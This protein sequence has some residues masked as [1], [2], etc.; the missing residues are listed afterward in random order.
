MSGQPNRKPNDPA[1]FRQDY[2]DALNLRAKVDDYNLQANKQY[3]ATGALPPAVTQMTDTRNTSE[4]LADTYKLKQSIIDD[5]KDVASSAMASLVVQRVEQDPLNGDGSFLQFIAQNAPEIV[6]QLK[7]KYKFGIKGDSNDVETMISYMRNMYAS[8]KDQTGTVKSF[9]DRPHGSTN[10]Q[11]AVQTATDYAKL[12][13]DLR[14]LSLKILRTNPQ[15][16]D[17]RELINSVVSVIQLSSGVANKDFIDGI[18][19]QLQIMIDQPQFYEPDFID[20]YNE[21]KTVISQLPK[22][23]QIRALITQLQKSSSNVNPELSKQI[24]VNI[25]SL[26]PNP[27]ILESWNDGGSN[28][29]LIVHYIIEQRRGITPL[30]RPPQPQPPPSQ[31]L[32]GLQGTVQGPPTEEGQYPRPTQQ[33]PQPHV[34]P[35]VPEAPQLQTH[36]GRQINVRGDL[37][38]FV[39]GISNNVRRGI[40]MNL[41]EDDIIHDVNRDTSNYWNQGLTDVQR[42][43]LRQKGITH[44]LLLLTPER[45][46]YH[47][48]DNIN[49]YFRS[50]PDADMMLDRATTEQIHTETLRDVY[51]DL[52]QNGATGEGLKKKRRGRPVGRGIGKSQ[53][54]IETKVDKASG[55][56]KNDIKKFVPF[57]KYFIHNVKLK[58][59]I[60]SLRQPSGVIVAG[61]SPTR[62]SDK[63]GHVIRT[64][65]GGGTPKFNELNGLSDEERDYLY[66]VSKKS[67]L[68]DK[69][70]VP[71]PS[72]DAME[73]DIHNF[74][75]MKGEIMAGNDSIDMI[76]KFKLLI[77]KLSKSGSLP[78]ND[79]HEILQE[80][81]VL[82]Y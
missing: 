79:V 51:E 72:K 52:I 24:L 17:L 4:I 19:N 78:K 81:I 56:K 63:L 68:E 73:K 55:I 11:S 54:F 7:K 1:D 33:L 31:H 15:D 40:N 28:R 39:T 80:L 66:K 70:S 12:N 65:V 25:S 41:S 20:L 38:R 8:I 6:V 10:M 3:K 82:G 71:S 64:I 22:P 76:K 27:Q 35:P 46:L 14:E 13:A 5:F 53:D 58:D 30:P 45:Y 69:F 77:L 16:V 57:G 50:H 60:I 26:F 59:N 18:D 43:E 2:M 74:E 21:Y 9:F 49:D 47:Y 62:V 37:A 75:V 42:N 29:N 32:I 48:T 44:N 34:P 67:D 23:S 61:M 36:T